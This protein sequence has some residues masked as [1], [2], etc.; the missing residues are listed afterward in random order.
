[1][2][3]KSIASN[4]VYQQISPQAISID[5]SDSCHW[6]EGQIQARIIKFVKALYLEELDYIPSPTT[7]K[8]EASDFFH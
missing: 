3:D 4:T 1:M 8:T 6:V 7:P 2:A 5:I